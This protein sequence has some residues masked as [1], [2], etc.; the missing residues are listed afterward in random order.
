LENKI[1]LELIA[2]TVTGGFVCW[3][4]YLGYKLRKSLFYK[5]LL[6]SSLIITI[7][8]IVLSWLFYTQFILFPKF[9]HT[10]NL[11]LSSPNVEVTK[12]LRT[13]MLKNGAK[14][15]GNICMMKV[16][17]FEHKIYSVDINKGE[18]NEIFCVDCNSPVYFSISN[19]AFI[20]DVE[21]FRES[22]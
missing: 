9:V 15:A 14:C 13:T 18:S 16:K 2:L 11:D 4:A 6:I 22:K 8:P 7:P 17:S 19:M 1:L 3:T 21:L 5:I 10:V 20:A 12:E